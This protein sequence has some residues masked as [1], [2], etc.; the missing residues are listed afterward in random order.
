MTN[1]SSDLYGLGQKDVH[2]LV[3]QL[4]AAVRLFSEAMVRCERGDQDGHRGPDVDEALPLLRRAHKEALKQLSIC[5][6]LLSILPPEDDDGVLALLR[7]AGARLE[8]LESATAA[9]GEGHLAVVNRCIQGAIIRLKQRKDI[10]DGLS[11]FYGHDGKGRVWSL[12]EICVLA[13]R[14]MTDGHA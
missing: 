3:R 5:E 1:M 14:I 9:W 8:L 2:V 11:E 7:I 6:E 4:G 12:P 10:G 13:E